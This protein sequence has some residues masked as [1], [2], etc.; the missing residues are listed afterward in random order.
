MSIELRLPNIDSSLP[1]EQQ[2][3]QLK[4]YLYQTVEQ[5]NWALSV[6]EKTAEGIAK[7]VEVVTDSKETTN[8][9][10]KDFNAIKDLIIKDADIVKAYAKEQEEIFDSSY[11]A[12]SEFGTYQADVVSTITT[13]AEGIKMDI[14]SEY[15]LSDMPGISDFYGKSQRYL[16]L[17]LLDTDA[18]GKDI[19]GLEIG[20]TEEG[21]KYARYDNTGTHLYSENGSESITIAEG[22]TKFS[23]N[24]TMD[25]L[26]VKGFSIDG[27]ERGIGLFWEG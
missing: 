12:Q 11:V 13:R 26:S 14:V 24:V 20:D 7:K 2:L 5:L 17:G 23:G 15:K 9:A 4:N 27:N 19:V 22:K 21:R 25:M 3:A 8:K 16:K 1:P 10:I 18:I 6:T